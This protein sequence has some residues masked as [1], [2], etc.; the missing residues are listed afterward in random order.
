M[1]REV[2][3]ICCQN[4]A[5]NGLKHGICSQRHYCHTDRAKIRNVGVERSNCDNIK[6]VIWLKSG[7]R[8][9]LFLVIGWGE[10]EDAKC[11]LNPTEMR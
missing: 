11:M 4:R 5:E 8:N 3:K 10:D 1:V 2:A 9:S 6:W 7:V